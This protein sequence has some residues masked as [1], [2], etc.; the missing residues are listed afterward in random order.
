MQNFKIISSLMC[1]MFL[2]AGCGGGGSDS[3]AAKQV[4]TLSFPLQTSYKARITSGANDILSVSGTCS[5][6]ADLSISTPDANA[7]ITISTSRFG[8][9]GFA[10]AQQL[11]PN[12]SNCNN[13]ASNAEYFFDTNYNLLGY[14][15]AS[16]VSNNGWESNHVTA[17]YPMATSV[18]VGD[19]AVFA[20]LNTYQLTNNIWDI[21]SSGNQTIS[22]VIEADTATTAIANLIT[23]GYNATNQL[24]FT[25]QMRYRVASNGTITLVSIDIQFS[26]TSTMHLLFTKT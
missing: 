6:T 26:T 8:A 14:D 12:F 25:Q 15:T 13:L 24:L 23:K 16:D 1:S 22:Y 17:I 5:G 10:T 9:S 20:T 3:A 21:I 18:H 4:S 2:I 7:F 19:T 11:V